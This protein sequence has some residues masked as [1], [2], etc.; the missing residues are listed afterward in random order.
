MAQILTMGPLS[1][2]VKISFPQGRFLAIVCSYVASDPLGAEAF[3]FNIPFL[4]K[5]YN[6][7]HS[8]SQFPTV[9]PATLLA[10]IPPKPKIVNPIST[11]MQKRLQAWVEPNP[12]SGASIGSAVAFINVTAIQKLLKN[13]KTFSFLILTSPHGTSQP[14][15]PPAAVYFVYTP[16]LFIGEGIVTFTP[17]EFLDTFTAK[18]NPYSEPSGAPSLPDIIFDVLGQNWNQPFVNLAQAQAVATQ[19]NAQGYQELSDWTVGKWNLGPP[20]P[21][22]N[23]T[24]S[25]IL[26]A[27]LF[28]HQKNLPVS[29]AGI[30]LWTA[31]PV[32]ISTVN[33]HGASPPAYTNK[34]TVSLK[35]LAV[36]I[37]QSKTP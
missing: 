36:H 31:K 2:L 6:G 22:P 1:E 10:Y 8:P 26:A 28:N 30:P 12:S 4:S 14:P 18:T 32:S 23:P 35:P 20:I 34:V 27:N 3:A 9:F 29:A 11:Q 24:C 13:P 17:T 16:F 15:L 25:W 5:D 7:T 21:P 37:N 33:S 19:M